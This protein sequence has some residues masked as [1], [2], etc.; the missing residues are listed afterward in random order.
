MMDERV[1]HLKNLKKA[2]L[3]QRRKAI[4]GWDLLHILLLVLLAV[5]AACLLYMM[6]YTAPL[7]RQMDALLWTPLKNLVGLTMSL[8]PVGL[9]VIMYGHYFVLGFL[10][11]WVLTLV[12]RGRAIAKT[13]KL[14]SYLDYN[15]M[16]ITLK[17]EKKEAKL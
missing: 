2:Y 8:K 16:R 9:F 10:V 11:L 12:L 7:V 1:Q 4:W 17:T 13:R 3:K 14:D 6:F 5:A 15:T